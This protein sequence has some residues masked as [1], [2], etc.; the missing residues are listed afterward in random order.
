MY[1]D[2]FIPPCWDPGGTMLMWEATEYQEGGLGGISAPS[3]LR[4]FPAVKALSVVLGCPKKVHFI[5]FIT[6]FHLN[7]STPGEEIMTLYFFFQSDFN[8]IHF[9]YNKNYPPKLDWGVH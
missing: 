9:C 3:W 2:I 7:M 1:V 6:N 8:S 4:D 5:H